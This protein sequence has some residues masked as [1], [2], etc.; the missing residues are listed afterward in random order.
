MYVILRF[1]QKIGTC[2]I[3]QCIHLGSTFELSIRDGANS[4]IESTGG[5]DFAIHR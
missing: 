3:T 4:G 1:L 2:L 5:A